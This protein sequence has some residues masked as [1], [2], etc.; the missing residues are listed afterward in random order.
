MHASAPPHVH[1]LVRAIPR[2]VLSDV[3]CRNG[4]LHT[5]RNDAR[6]LCVSSS[7]CT[8]PITSNCAAARFHDHVNH[9]HADAPRVSFPAA[10]AV[11]GKAPT[12]I[13]LKRGGDM[14][15]V[16]FGKL[17]V[18]RFAEAC[19]D[20]TENECVHCVA[21]SLSAEASVYDGWRGAFH[22]AGPTESRLCPLLVDKLN[23]H[24][25]FAACAFQNCCRYLFF[26]RF[27]MAMAPGERGRIKPA[28]VRVAAAGSGAPTVPL[29]L[30][31]ER[32]LTF[33]HDEALSRIAPRFGN[34]GVNPRMIAWVLTVPAIWDDEAKRFM[35]EAAMRAGMITKIDSARLLLALEPEGAVVASLFEAAPAVRALFVPGTRILVADCGGGTVDITVSELRSTQPLQLVEL[36]PASGGAWGACYADTE[37]LKFVK[38][39]VGDD[40]YERIDHSARVKMLQ[41]WHDHVVR[42]A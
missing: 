39:L 20:G 7:C 28:Q 37:F 29:M 1:S 3:T 10:D 21:L 11:S 16:A 17:A 24:R 12:A 19:D 13:L 6:D 27:K 26:D 35:R 40:D 30:P 32:T 4:A 9:A 15:T 41:S 22:A 33:I 36:L 42:L 25:R 18:E 38:L 14:R 8:L 34:L 2:P 5:W 23:K 31:V